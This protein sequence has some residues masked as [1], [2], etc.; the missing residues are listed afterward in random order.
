MLVG[1]ERCDARAVV[2][3]AFD[4]ARAMASPENP[5]TVDIVKVG[6]RWQHDRDELRH[7]LDGAP[8]EPWLAVHVR[9]AEGDMGHTIA[10]AATHGF[11]DVV[12]IDALGAGVRR[13]IQH[14]GRPVIAVGALIEGSNARENGHG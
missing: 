7:L 13:I 4:L 3:Q 9:F 11:Y 14:A 10:R 6:E 12:V 5:I 2:E 8:S 1:I